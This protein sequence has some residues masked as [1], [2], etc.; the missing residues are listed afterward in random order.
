[1]AVITDR[2]P[3]LCPRSQFSRRH[4]KPGGYIEISEFIFDIRSDDGTLSGSHLERYFKEFKSASTKAGFKY[5]DQNELAQR[6][7][8]MGFEDIN[9]KQFKQPWGMW[10][11]NPEMKKIGT[12]VQMATETGFDVGDPSIERWIWS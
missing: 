1:M 3:I 4:T 10:P 2:P 11:K 9:I 6:L 5:P 12:M 7:G 8:E